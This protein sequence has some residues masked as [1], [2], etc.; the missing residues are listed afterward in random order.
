MEK[1][2]SFFGLFVMML[3]AWLLSTNRRRIE[4]RV[5][6]GGLLLQFILALLILKTDTGR[7]FFDAAN[8]FVTTLIGFSD[9]GS[10]FLF[11]PDFK[12]HFF[13]F[14]VLPTIIFVSSISY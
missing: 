3:L 9:K 14:S 4:P 11:G 7:S 8:A 6:I 5:V 10:E 12:D 1:W 2:L 13:A